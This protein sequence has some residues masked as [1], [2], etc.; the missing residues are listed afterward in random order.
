MKSALIVML[1]LAAG[2]AAYAF[3]R[4]DGSLVTGLRSGGKQFLIFLPVIFAACVIMGLTQTL[5]PQRLVETWLSDASGFRGIGVAWIAGALTPGGSL[6]GMPL[7]AGLFKAGVGASVLVTYLS[8]L[9]LLSLVRVPLEI[10]LI[11]GRLTAIRVVATLLLPPV[12][13]LLTRLI[14]GVIK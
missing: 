2:L 3:T 14:V 10:S 7:V 8:S 5:L 12:A 1:L 9:A 4:H 13:G 11:G 6:V